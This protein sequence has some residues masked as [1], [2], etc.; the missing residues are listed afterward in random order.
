MTLFLKSLLRKLAYVLAGI[1]ILFA[2]AILIGRLLAPVIDSHRPDVEKWASNVLGMPVTIS[3]IDASWYHY[4]PDISLQQV[5]AYNK[6]TH[7]PALQIR[8]I[9]IFFSI[10]KSLWYWKPVPAGFILI[11]ANINI[12]QSSKGELNVQGFPAFKQLQP[13]PYPSETKF[14][15]MITWLSTQPYLVLRDI[16]VNYKG[17][18]GQSRFVTLH[19]LVFQN[20]GDHHRVF[21]RAILHQLT[22]TEVAL[23]VEWD[24]AQA[25]LD[26]IT[27]K[28]YLYASGVSLTQWLKTASWRGW[29]FKD[30]LLDAKIWLLWAQGKP[31][32]IQTTF[33][34]DKLNVYSQ[35]DKSQH[36]IKR[37]SGDLAWSRDGQNQILS[38]ENLLLELPTHA[39]PMTHFYLSLAPNAT[40]NLAPKMIDFSYLNLEDAQSFLLSSTW[41][42][43]ALHQL[44]TSL[45]LRGSLQNTVIVFANNGSNWQQN[46]I[47][48]KLKGIGFAAI[49]T[50]PGIEN[51]TG[52][53]RWDGSQ[54]G[55]R[56]DSDHLTFQDSALFISAL[57]I[58][59]LSGSLQWQQDQN[60][61]WVLQTS[62]LQILNHDMAA[63]VNGSISIAKNAAIK[64][65][66]DA[67]FTVLNVNHICNYLPLKIFDASL[68]AWLQQAFLAGEI[69]SGHLELRGALADFPFNQGQGKFLVKGQVTNVDFNYAPKWPMM[70]H[71][72]GNLIFADNKITIDLDHAAIDNI[73]LQAV[74][75]EIFHL[76]DDQASLLQVKAE[77]I[78]T[79]LSQGL[80]FIHSSPLEKTLGKMFDGVN[81]QGKTVLQLGLTLPVSHPDEVKIQANLQL[82][83]AELNA[84]AWHLALSHLNGQVQFTEST[85]SAK[86]LTGT[87][88]TRPLQISLQTIKTGKNT[89]LIRAIFTNSVNISD[90]EHWL[91]LPSTSVLKG[92]IALNGEIDLSSTPMNI[93]VNSNLQGVSIKLPDGYGKTAAEKRNM[94]LSII[95]ASANDQATKIKINYGDLLSSALTLKYQHSKYQVIGVNLNLGK[96]NITWPT[97]PGLYITGQFAKLDWDNVKNYLS[98][99]SNSMMPKLNLRGIDV[100]ADLV[101]VLGQQLT[102]VDLQLTLAQ[103]NWNINITSSQVSGRLQIPVN[104]NRKGLINVYL[105][106]MSLNSK[107]SPAKTMIDVASLPAIAFV[108]N[109]VKYDDTRLGKITFKTLPTSNGLN[110]QYLHIVSPR[111]DLQSDGD[112][113]QVKNTSITHLHGKI[114]SAKVSDLINSFGFDAHNFISDQGQLTFNLNWQDAPYAPS[115]AGL[116]GSASLNLGPGRVVDIGASNG[117]KMDLGRMLSIFSLQTIPRRL[118]LDF[119]DVF[120]KG[121]SFDSVKGDFNFQKGSA[122]T[123]NLHFDGPVARV[124]IDGRIGLKNKDYDFMLAVTAHVTGSLP[125]AAAVVGGPIAGIAALAVNTV[126]GSQVSKAATYY[127][128]VTGTWD[129][130]V[131]KAEQGK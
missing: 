47:K 120:Q 97:A 85:V 42:S 82:N 74:H 14:T 54:G 6:E 10:P 117:A 92:N 101:Q 71:A 19:K 110:I 98:E 22:P 107:A 96:G 90:V 48:T 36:K 116:N 106:K 94:M 27:G 69:N 88:L 11:G 37:I 9:T 104:F 26:K 51:L 57:H 24:G 38:G 122:Y 126:I 15:G 128:S 127:Y 102:Q 115:L 112:W 33:R 29:Q 81:L 8:K 41:L 46:Y 31:Q 66:L 16:D 13:Q 121:Y 73:P 79:S 3:K 113:K 99:S 12:K 86:Q 103:N 83:N 30:G 49:K 68:S 20:N 80:H 67:N 1:I 111:M 62:S 108:A 21:G 87:W 84:A 17:W 59:Q 63:N 45:K 131:W 39:W 70:Y 129:N 44:L 43:E 123:N 109:H 78:Q 5:T 114:I 105:D 125:V 75:A 60:Q 95:A 65:N 18:L 58:D 23:G 32:K 119:S 93:R 61:A 4:Q 40:N 28:A 64:T 50:Y 55:F 56:F 130:P 124:G 76:T 89:S 53:L 7:A 34:A 35:T 25:D 52:E 118:S 91:K 72:N 2:I 100:R 77:N